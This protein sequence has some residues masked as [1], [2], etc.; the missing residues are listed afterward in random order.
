MFD[1]PTRQIAA[2][3]LC[4]GDRLADG[5]VVWATIGIDG[6]WVAVQYVIDDALWVRRYHVAA[7]VDVHT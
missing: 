4:H 3:D 7:R 2:A 1:T 5:S 6:H